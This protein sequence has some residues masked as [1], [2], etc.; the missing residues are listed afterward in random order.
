MTTFNFEHFDFID[1]DLITLPKMIFYRGIMSND[2]LTEKEIIRNSPIYLGSKNI[3]KDY[4]TVYQLSTP[5]SLRLVD[6]RKLKT[7]LNIVISS[8]KSN[9]PAILK[10]IQYLTM[11]FGLC[12]YSRQ[13]LELES[14]V[15]DARHLVNDHSELDSV[16][17][18]INMM[19]N[20][21]PRH[22]YLNPIEPEGVRVAE[23]YIDGKVM[24]ILKDL[25]KGIY[26]GFIAP[27]MFSPFHSGGFTHEEIVIFDPIECGFH[28]DT[29]SNVKS[30]SLSKFLNC[31]GDKALTIKNEMYKSEI[32]I[33]KNKHTKPDS[34]GTVSI[35]RKIDRNIFFDDKDQ[36]NEAKLD[37]KLFK[38]SVARIKKAKYLK[39]NLQ[40]KCDP[41]FTCK[42]PKWNQ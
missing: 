37:A 33:Q 16:Y 6:V 11:A 19:R 14:H 4:G 8:R 13:I 31:R 40:L 10:S 29:T 32:W 34:G 7:I 9:E 20:T 35:S 38:K 1:T 25:F 42:L 21:D 5:K 28:L 39:P 3:A 30:L 17:K 23:T 27:A 15:D 24:I 2:P 18:K 36:V 22:F 12:S 41:D 26:D